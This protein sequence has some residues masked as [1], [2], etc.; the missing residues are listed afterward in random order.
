MGLNFNLVSL[1]AFQWVPLSSPETAVVWVSVGSCE[2]LWA[3]KSLRI[4]IVLQRFDLL[5]L[6][7]ASHLQGCFYFLL[8]LCYYSLCASELKI[9]TF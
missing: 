7:S 5:L 1:Y 2:L 4:I 8:C 6:V 3:N 9:L